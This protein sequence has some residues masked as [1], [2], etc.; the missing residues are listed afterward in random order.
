MSMKSQLGFTLIELLVAL[1]I[2]TLLSVAGYRGLDAVLQARERVSAETR[3]WQH[4]AF[5]FSRMN[6]DIAQAVRRPVRDEDGSIVRAAWVG[7]AVTVG[8]NAELIFTRAGIPDQ[9]AA[10]QAPQRIGYHLEQG[11]IVMLRWPSLDQAPRAKPVRYPVLEGVRE[12]KLRYLDKDGVWQPQ[13][14]YPT[15]LSSLPLAAEVTLTLAGGEVITRLFAL[16]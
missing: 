1:V 12:F 2:L 6:Q 3:K 14:Q 8:E 13:W 7:T 5:F 11:T 15:D 4:L 10:L 9:G 16:Q